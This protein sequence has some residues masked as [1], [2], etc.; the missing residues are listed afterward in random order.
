MQLRDYQSELVEQTS[1]IL[2]KFKIVYL[3]LETRVGKTPVSLVSAQATGKPEILFCTKADEN[4]MQSIKKTLRELQEGG[5][6]TTPVKIVSFDS[7]HKETW[8][9]ERALIVDEAHSFGAYPKPVLRAKMLKAITLCCP[10]ILLSATPTPESCAQIYHQ[11]WACNAHTFSDYASFYK[12]A[13]VFVEVKKK[14]IGAGRE[15]NDYSR[16]KWDLIYPAI[17]PILISYTKEEAGFNYTSVR[18]IIVQIACPDALKTICKTLRKEK[19]Y[20]YGSSEIVA[21]TGA[22]L[23]SKL[24]Q[25]YSGTVIDEEGNRLIISRHKIP[26]IRLL[27]TV[28]NKIAIYY[29]FIAELELLVETFGDRI[30][31]DAEAFAG[32]DSLIFVAQFQS[33]REGVNLATANALVFFNMDYAFVS[34]WQTLNRIQS[35]DRQT[36]PIAYF[37]FTEGGIE[38][39]IYHVVK[40]R[41]KNFTLSYFKAEERNL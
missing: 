34:Y 27:L 20:N 17:E 16:G 2:A 37:L 25:L 10:V 13:K 28:H 22:S 31:S 8:T 33:G 11:L 7:L 1:K 21:D 3:T 6:M 35:F 40:D 24:H 9:P 41:K 15:A 4:N 19:L 5:V 26:R 12:W 18:E 38:E 36:E 14:F 23:M 32:S 29:K 30:T 39:K